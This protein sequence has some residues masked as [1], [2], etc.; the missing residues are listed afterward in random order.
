MCALGLLSLNF[1]ITQKKKTLFQEYEVWLW[2]RTTFF[3]Q[4]APSKYVDHSEFL[5]WDGEKIG[6]MGKKHYH[7]YPRY[8]TVACTIRIIFS[9]GGGGGGATHQILQSVQV[10]N[11]SVVKCNVHYVCFRCTMSLVHKLFKSTHVYRE[12][13]PVEY[14]FE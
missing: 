6:D 14:T 7:Y 5:D 11:N 13:G 8:R 10:S 12:N 4:N 3:W 1:P 2:L 9:E